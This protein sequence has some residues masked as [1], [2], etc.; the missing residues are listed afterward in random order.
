MDTD[1][2]ANPFVVGRYVSPQYFCDREHET[3]LLTKHIDNGRNI[4][5]ISPRRMGKTGIIRH[6]FSQGGLK[7]RYHLI[8]IDIYATSSL[9]ELTYM[10]A[11]AVYDNL[12]SK[13]QAWFERFSQVVRSLRMGFKIDATSG[14]PTFDIGL[15]D[16]SAPEETLDE[17]FRYLEE[18]DRPCV[19]AIDEFQQI[20][21]YPEENVEAL[22]R[23]KIQTCR[24]TQFI[25]AGSKRHVM[26]NMFLSSSKPFY[27]SAIIMGLDPIPEE[28]YV[29]FAVR[30]F[31]ERGK[32]VDP[33]VVSHVYRRFDGCTWFVQ[34]MMNELFA[35]TP[36]GGYCGQE[37]VDTA[38]DNVIQSQEGAYTAI[39]SRLSPRQKVILQA[40][41][42]EGVASSITSEE[43][44]ARYSLGSASSVQAAVKPLLK[45]DILTREDDTYRVYDYFFREWMATVY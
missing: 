7:E 21:N 17:I 18:A 6:A 37:A 39:L 36:D 8:F 31:G 34:M 11:K 20:G 24:N 43:F 13:R 10:L 1:I 27:Q 40:I 2:I 4:A 12:K 42:R 35:I 15:G 9:P 29:E 33:N 28:R 32:S 19:V 5:L 45:N 22:L 38:F 41:A 14:E 3:S 44:I 30:L 26:G 25:F 16:I 23:T